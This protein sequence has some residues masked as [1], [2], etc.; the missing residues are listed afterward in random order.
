MFW[1]SEDGYNRSTANVDSQSAEA[2][3]AAAT[4]LSHTSGVYCSNNTTTGV[5]IGGHMPANSNLD[6]SSLSANHSSSSCH[7]TN[8][9]HDTGNKRLHVS[10]IPFR[11]RDPDLRVMFEVSVFFYF[12]HKILLIIADELVSHCSFVQ[13]IDYY[14]LSEN[15]WIESTY[16]LFSD[17]S[18][19]LLMIAIDLLCLF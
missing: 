11:Y 15:C 19:S 14:S 10:N 12:E 8:L 2:A 9:L 4:G 17:H 6:H 5:V 3:V 16:K 7:A 13:N 18:F 1:Q